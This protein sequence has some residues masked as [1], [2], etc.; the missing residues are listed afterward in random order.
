MDEIDAV[1]LASGG[2][3]IVISLTAAA[4]L[5]VNALVVAGSIVGTSALMTG[6]GYLCMRRQRKRPRQTE[7]E[8]SPEMSPE[9]QEFLRE[10]AAFRAHMRELAKPI[11][12]RVE[13]EP[14]A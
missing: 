7:V 5:S 4:L 12:P 3:I 2:A 13:K 8:M 10:G 6:A 11:V 1:G 14:T 9:M